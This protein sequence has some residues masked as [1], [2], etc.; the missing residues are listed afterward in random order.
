MK[1]NFFGASGPKPAK[2]TFSNRRKPKYTSS[3]TLPPESTP[4]TNLR[5]CPENGY[6]PHYRNLGLKSGASTEGIKAA[7]RRT[8][9]R[10]HPD[11]IRD[12]AQKKNATAAMI[13]INEAYEKLHTKEDWW[14]GGSND[15]TMIDSSEYL[16]RLSE[17][18]NN[19]VEGG[20][21][22]EVVR[23]Q[24]W[25]WA[26]KN[27]RQCTRD[28][29]L[30][31]G[32]YWATLT[33]NTVDSILPARISD[34]V[35]E[36]VD[37]DWRYPILPLPAFDKLTFYGP[38]FHT[39]TVTLPAVKAAK[40]VPPPLWSSFS[41]TECN[42]PLNLES[43]DTAA[44][45]VLLGTIQFGFRKLWFA[46]I[47][48]SFASIIFC[49]SFCLWCIIWAAKRVFWLCTWPIRKLFLAFSFLFRLVLQKLPDISW[50]FEYVVDLG[51]WLYFYRVRHKNTIHST[52]GVAGRRFDGNCA[53]RD[54]L[55]NMY[56]K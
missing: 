51:R 40:T 5:K 33:H 39:Y 28:G 11:K 53:S 45:L 7:W 17:K 4:K 52:R 29:D 55:R 2:E 20:G 43:L 22:E 6:I 42:T 50:V 1:F 56:G 41:D 18:L 35:W 21:C 31:C 47:A 26:Y 10:L 30:L 19:E 34:A 54:R 16:R 49:L 25:F 14:R 38:C 36:L 12:S 15:D 46:L 24:P 32:E 9:L 37:M 23:R 48:Y 3:S 13:L 27:E 44:L 8:I